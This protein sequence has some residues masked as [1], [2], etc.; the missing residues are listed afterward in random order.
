MIK[1]RFEIGQ[2][3]YH[4]TPESPKGF[5]IDAVYSL[6]N[7]RWRYIVAFSINNETTCEEFEL[8]ENKI[9]I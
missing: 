5:I 9:L 1:N 4:I 6:L 2:N 8:S 7:N 3:I